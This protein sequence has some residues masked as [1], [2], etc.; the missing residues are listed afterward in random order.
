MTVK[1]IRTINSAHLTSE[2]WQVQFEGLEACET[3]EYRDTENCGGQE[4]RETGKN[5]M[6]YKVPLE[7]DA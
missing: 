6:G 7:N 1:A 4:I 5:D 3:C 2:C